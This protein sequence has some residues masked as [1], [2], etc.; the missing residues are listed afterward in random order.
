M[1]T[2]KLKINLSDASV[3]DNAGFENID[4]GY[5]RKVDETT[6]L[7]LIISNGLYYPQIEQIGEFSNSESQVVCLKSIKYLHELKNIWS[8][9]TESKL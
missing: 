7:R 9:L 3:L 2:E 1:D 8:T 5:H 6:T 4:Y